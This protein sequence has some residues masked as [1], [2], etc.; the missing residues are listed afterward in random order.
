MQYRTMPGSD[1]KLSVLGYGCMRLPTKGRLVSSI[2][3]EESKKQILYAIEGGVNYLDTAYPYHKGESESFLGKHILKDGYREKVNVATKLPTFIINKKER[4][5][6]IFTKQ[7]SKLGV[8]YIDYYLLHAI[9]GSSWEKMKEL[10]IIEW[11]DAIRKQGR[12]RKLGFSYHGAYED[13]PGVVGDYDWDFTQIQYNIL[14]EN[15]QAGRKGIEYAHEKGLGV[16]VMEPLRG[17]SLSAKLPKEIAQIYKSSGTQRS[18]AQWALSWVLD[19]PAVTLLLSGMNDMNHIKENIET[20][21]HAFAGSMTQQEKQ[22]IERVKEK[23]LEMM[24]VGCTSCGYCMPCPVGINIPG[25]FKDLN[26]YHMF[27][28]PSAKFF[29]IIFNAIMT[30]DGKPH[31]AASCIECGECEKKCPQDIE[32]RKE[33]K[34]VKK[35]MEGPVMRAIACAARPIANAGKKKRAKR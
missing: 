13:F 6:E 1:E 7:L 25:N 35:E 19:N 15:L 8:E 24:A 3:V 16:I 2:D 22:L 12:A 26:S 18:P 28:K 32:I 34:R 11:M 20:V 9:N 4:I 5:E 27:R 23:Y 17:G 33:L 14:D 29:H 10:G 30:R 31:L 21:S